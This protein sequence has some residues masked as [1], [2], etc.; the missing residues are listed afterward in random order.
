MHIHVHTRIICFGR[1]CKLQ[2]NCFPFQSLMANYKAK[3]AG[4]TLAA[5]KKLEEVG[6]QYLQASCI[7]RFRAHV[8]CISAHRRHSWGLWASRPP[9]NGMVAWGLHEILF[10]SI[11][12][13]NYEMRTLSKVMTFPK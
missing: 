2:Q 7:R 8:P 4:Q 5:M 1:S 10:Y 11:M 13:M 12:Y 6:V 9:D 3:K